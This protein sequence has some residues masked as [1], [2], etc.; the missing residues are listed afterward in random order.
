MNS[1]KSE[2]NLHYEQHVL[3]SN[4]GKWQDLDESHQRFLNF[5]LLHQ[6]SNILNHVRWMMFGFILV[7][8][9]VP[10]LVN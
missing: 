3:I 7:T 10:F 2:E 5:Q 6:I 8:I 1:K 9:V 4:F